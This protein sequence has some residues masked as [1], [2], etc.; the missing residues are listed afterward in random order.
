[1]APYGAVRSGRLTVKGRIRE[2]LQ[3]DGIGPVGIVFKPDTEDDDETMAQ[4]L[5]GSVTGWMLEAFGSDRAK[6]KPTHPLWNSGTFKCLVLVAEGPFYRR[7]GLCS[8]KGD[9]QVKV[10][11]ASLLRTFGEPQTITI[12]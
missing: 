6:V 12:I 11:G 5:Q 9:S 8:L 2:I 3:V 10:T 7:I 4:I 1:M